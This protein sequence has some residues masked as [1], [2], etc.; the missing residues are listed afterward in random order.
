M[1]FCNNFTRLS[2]DM[3]KGFVS[4]VVRVDHCFFQTGLDVIWDD[5]KEVL[6]SPM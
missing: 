6:L 1:R 3:R 4:I 5:G 2:I